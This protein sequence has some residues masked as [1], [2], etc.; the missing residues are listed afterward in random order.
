MNSNK[1]AAKPFLTVCF[2]G[3]IGV[4]TID[5]ETHFNKQKKRMQYNKEVHAMKTY[6]L[7]RHLTTIVTVFAA[8]FF[9][10]SC[11]C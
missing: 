5:V 9:L 7:T 3:H 10:A 11:A 2:F 4:Y 8:I 1:R 6:N